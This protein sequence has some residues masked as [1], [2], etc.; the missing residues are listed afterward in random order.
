MEDIPKPVFIKHD[1]IPHDVLTRNQVRTINVIIGRSRCLST[2]ASTSIDKLLGTGA[3]QI[4]SKY[5]KSRI[6]TINFNPYLFTEFMKSDHY[7]SRYEVSDVIST[8]RSLVEDKIFLDLYK[9]SPNIE[10]PKYGSLDIHN[11]P[12]VDARGY[13]ECYFILDESVRRRVTVTNCDSFNPSAVTGVCDWMMHVIAKLSKQELQ[14][15]YDIACG[16]IDTTPVKFSYVEIQIHG[17]L[18]FTH[19][20]A[21]IHVPHNL[22]KKLV[23]DGLMFAEKFGIKF[24]VDE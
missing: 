17:L 8:S 7:K 24:V 13:G 5:C 10:R 12:G 18:R 4:I 20:I 16:K 6:M 11:K 23:H 14:I 15:I 19:D 22:D 21:E 9:D 2:E 3:V 1:D